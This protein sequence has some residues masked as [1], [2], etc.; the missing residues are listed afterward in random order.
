[1]TERSLGSWDDRGCWPWCASST[2]SPWV[3]T[4]GSSSTYSMAREAIE[5]YVEVTHADGLPVPTV[6]RGRL[7]V[8]AA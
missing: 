5:A 3:T 8:R 1:M 2:V 7:A 4:L 6:Q